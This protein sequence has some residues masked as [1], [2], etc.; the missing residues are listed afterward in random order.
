MILV[1]K[2]LK[3]SVSVPMYHWGSSLWHQTTGIQLISKYRYPQIRDHL[4]GDPSFTHPCFYFSLLTDE[5]LEKH[6]QQMRSGG[7]SPIPRA[8]TNPQTHSGAWAIPLKGFV[9][10]PPSCFSRMKPLLPPTCFRSMA[11][12]N[13]E[14]LQAQGYRTTVPAIGWHW[15]RPLLLLFCQSPILTEAPDAPTCPPSQLVT[16]SFPRAEEYGQTP[17]ITCL[18]PSSAFQVH[19]DLPLLITHSSSLGCPRHRS[20]AALSCSFLEITADFPFEAQTSSKSS[21]DHCYKGHHD[22]L[23]HSAESRHEGTQ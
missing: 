16:S 14:F 17:A 5:S 20:H 18:S 9:H 8:L 4:S 21:S 7:A 19:A 1:L 2:F 23:I 6:I 10:E 11:V 15:P 13:I 22:L 3:T 12:L